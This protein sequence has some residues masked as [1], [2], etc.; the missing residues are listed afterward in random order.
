MKIKYKFITT[1]LIIIFFSITIFN[2]S[3]SIFLNNESLKFE[4]VD[5][6]LFQKNNLFL[7]KCANGE[8]RYYITKKEKLSIDTNYFKNLIQGVSYC[9]ETTK[10]N[11]TVFDAALD[12]QG[13]HKMV[14][15]ND[16]IWDN[17]E[18]VIELY[19]SKSLKDVYIQRNY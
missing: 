13:N 16:L 5:T 9:F 14:I 18:F 10:L 6:T 11:K 1:Y 19:T 17:G 15:N 2:C 12:M 8:K 7:F 4:W 3:S